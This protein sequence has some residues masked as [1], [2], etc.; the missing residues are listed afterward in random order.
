MA[1]FCLST[2]YAENIIDYIIKSIIQSQ[3]LTSKQTQIR[4][5]GKNENSLTST[6]KERWKAAV[7]AYQERNV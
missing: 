1:C 6:T 3:I 5:N 2:P 7:K 4:N